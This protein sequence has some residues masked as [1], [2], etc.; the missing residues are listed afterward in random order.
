MT[1]LHVLIIEDDVDV[2]KYIA[3][4]LGEHGF[5]TDVA[6]GGQEGFDKAVANIYDLLIV[7]R[8][9]PEL[10]GLEIISRLRALGNKVPILILSALGEV[11]NR[12][13]GFTAGGD[14]YL[15]KPYAFTELLARVQALTR[16]ITPE[17]QGSMMLEVADLRLDRL[18]RKVSRAGQRINL[19]P[20]EFRLLEYLMAHAGQVITRSMLLERVWEYHFDPQTNVIDVHISRLRNK[21]DKDFSPQLIHTERGMGYLLDTSPANFFDKKAGDKKANEKNG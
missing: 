18:R 6:H 10:D 4:G 21:I 3:K 5:R 15:V 20:R 13:E 12:V 11:D 8:M 7:D 17:V 1:D 16:R 9:L 2:A 14:D 19:Q